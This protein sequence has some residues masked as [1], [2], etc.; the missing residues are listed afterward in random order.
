MQSKNTGP[1]A[2]A[3]AFAHRWFSRSSPSRISMP[4]LRAAALVALLICAVT[5]TSISS[6]AAQ[7]P[8]ADAM[9]RSVK[10][11][12]DFYRYVN[13]GWLKWAAIHAGQSSYDDRTML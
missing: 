13:A 6:S 2:Y 4:R 7:N 11:G 10:P 5:L 1:N 12:D 9:D 3:A 8:S